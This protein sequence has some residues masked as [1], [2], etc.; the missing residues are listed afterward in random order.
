MKKKISILTACYNEEENV[1]A[2]IE[3]VDDVFNQLPQYDYEHV[4]IDNASEDKTVEI[5]EGI[6][7]TNKRIKVIVNSRNFGHIRSPFYG[8]LQ[9][10]GDA[11][12]S[13][14]A[15]FQDPPELIKDFVEKW[16]QGYKI[17]V[18]V[19]KKSL[20]N[21]IMFGI[22]KFYY[23]LVKS[24]AEVELIDNFT[25]FGL[26]DQQIVEVLRQ[27]D[28]PY[29]YFR[30]LICEVGFEKAIIEYSQPKRREGRTKNNFF[31]LFDMSMT[32]FTSTSKVP[33]RLASFIGFI[34][35]I[36]TMTIGLVYLVLKL[37]NWYKFDAGTA[38]I[39]LGIFF[40]GSI[41]LFFTGVIGEYVA[42]IN[43]RVIK[44]PLVVEKTRINF[45]D[46]ED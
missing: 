21:G 18:G 30:G 22:R 46:K 44:R 27:V 20:E 23:R 41:Q 39:L 8:I 15:D 32:G 12:L 14:V 1:A 9:C 34:L 29:P 31:T 42:S 2:L 13:L 10:K 37:V 43:T 28:D 38:P 5:L 36:I 26:Y 11:V 24:M 40:F 19:K 7:K 6:A 45:D 16:E 3:A 33:I 35:S 17:V 25:G 4:F